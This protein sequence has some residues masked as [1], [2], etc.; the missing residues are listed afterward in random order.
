V[1]TFPTY[2]TDVAKLMLSKGAMVII[3]SST[4][5]NPWESGT[6]SYGPSRFSTYAKAVVTAL[7]NPNCAFV[8]HGQYVANEYKTLG[9]TTVDS[10]FPND[11]THT[12]P[13]GATV[14]EKAFMK[15]LMCG[16]S[17][18]SAYSKNTTA[19]IEGSCF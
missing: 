7:N 5:N 16:G 11:H 3:S 12:S 13:A 4:P 6:F 17:A 15:G 1:Q 9:K 19:S 14:V 18:L 10:F 8:D 2:M